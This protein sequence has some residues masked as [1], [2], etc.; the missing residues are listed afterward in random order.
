MSISNRVNPIVN[1]LLTLCATSLVLILVAIAPSPV[2]AQSQVETYTVQPG[3][4]LG[5]IATQFDVTVEDLVTANGLQDANVLEVGQVLIIPTG[6]SG[7]LPPSEWTTVAA[8]PRQTLASLAARYGLEVNQL[9]AYNKVRESTRLFPG[10]P[11]RIPTERVQA[12]GEAFGA[13][14][15]LPVTT[16]LEQGRTG[17]VQV[18]IDRPV[19]V[20]VTWN[21]LPLPLIPES[22]QTDPTGKWFAPI[23][24]P[25][26][27]ALG[28]YPLEI[29]Y[30]TSSG[31]PLTRTLLVTVRDGGYDSQNIILDDEKSGLLAPE[32]V[33]AEEARVSE[34]WAQV[35]PSLM[36]TGVFSRPITSDYPTTSPFGTR[37]SYNGGPQSSYHAGQDFGAP[38][39]VPIYAPAGG[40]VILAEALNV[41]GN[42]VIIDHGRGIFTGY[43]HMNAI[44]VQQ[45]QTVQ[46]GDLLGVVGTT[47]LSTG[48]HLHWELR[49]FGIA[50]DPMQFLRQTLLGQVVPAAGS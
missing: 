4:T 48:N 47:G 11:I 46:P 37:R 6:Q 40:T 16:M 15:I 34:I 42:A 8:Y 24:V 14:Q 29:S 43:W 22:G 2:L 13:V 18:Q 41:R 50:V 49:I 44:N 31:I 9:A 12:A 5:L 1:L 38:A 30:T 25:A 10:Q 32:V 23:P 45:G 27:I 3:D 35:S 28:S 36:W 21:G 19:S 33:R 7:Q 17:V 39:D 20:N 26:L